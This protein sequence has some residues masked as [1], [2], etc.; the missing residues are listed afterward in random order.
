[1]GMFAAVLKRKT[2][3]KQDG[4]SD[5][6]NKPVQGAPMRFAFGNGDQP[7]SGYT[8]KRG[9]GIGGFGEVYFA[10]NDAARKLPQT[11]PTKF[12]RRSPRCSPVHQ[13]PTSESG[14][15]L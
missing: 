2:V 5:S 3:G 14:W 11:H 13:P 1:M 9:V 12:G 7:L 6:D 8:I 15:P 10:T 4:P